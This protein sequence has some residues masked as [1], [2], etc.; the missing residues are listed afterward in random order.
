M[1]LC[2][3]NQRKAPEVFL[4]TNCEK[5]AEGIMMVSAGPGNAGQY[6]V[7]GAKP[8]DQ[9]PGVTPLPKLT[10]LLFNVNIS[11]MCLC[12]LVHIGMQS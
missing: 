10:T 9:V 3:H 5:T 2:K 1:K 7:L 11:F 4:G 6:W 12:I 8:W